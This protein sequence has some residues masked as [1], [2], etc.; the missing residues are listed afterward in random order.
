MHCILCFHCLYVPSKALYETLALVFLETLCVSL[1]LSYIGFV[2][3]SCLDFCLT[4]RNSLGQKNLGAFLS[5]FKDFVQ[6][7]PT[8]VNTAGVVSLFPFNLCVFLF[9]ISGSWCC[10]VW[11]FFVIFIVSWHHSSSWLKRCLV[12]FIHVLMSSV[13]F[14]CCSWKACK[15]FSFLFFPLTKKN[16]RKD[17]LEGDIFCVVSFYWVDFFFKVNFSI[18]PKGLIQ[19]WKMLWSMTSQLTRK[20]K[21]VLLPTNY[22]CFS[23]TAKPFQIHHLYLTVVFTPYYKLNAWV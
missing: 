22:F 1:E 12:V 16:I 18:Y 19:T 14:Q 21:P 11:H 5:H 15:F 8:L 2:L 13:N 9:D 6:V 10:G 17:I 23:P 7:L 20:D 3:T 4:I